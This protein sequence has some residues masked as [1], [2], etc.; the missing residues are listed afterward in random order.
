MNNSLQSGQPGLWEE[1]ADLQSHRRP[2]LDHRHVRPSCHQQPTVD[3]L[4]LELEP[5]EQELRDFTLFDKSY[6]ELD[7]A[8][9]ELL[10]RASIFEEAVPVEALRWM[11]GDEKEPSPPVDKPLEM[12]LHWGLMARQEEREETLYSVHTKVRDFVGQGRRRRSKSCWF[13]PPSTMS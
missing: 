3:G 13:G 7:E 4:L 5:L 10:L 6:S 1:E 9:K 8:A 12:L 2:S 11:M